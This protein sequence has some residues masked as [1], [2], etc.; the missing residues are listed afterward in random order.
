MTA[1]D[2]SLWRDELKTIY[3]KYVANHLGDALGASENEEQVHAWT[4][5]GQGAYRK[6]PSLLTAPLIPLQVHAEFSQQRQYMERAL[7]AL[8][9][10]VARTED[11]TRL[12][13]QV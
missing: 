12:D 11:K 4:C 10:R 13:F 6:G 5:L 8:K 9:T 7:D 3:R 1:T 2:P